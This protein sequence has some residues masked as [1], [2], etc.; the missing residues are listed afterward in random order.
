MGIEPIPMH[1]VKILM[2]KVCSHVTKFGPKIQPDNH[3]FHGNSVVMF[4]LS[5]FDSLFFVRT[6]I[7]G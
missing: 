5:N 2:V 6:S 3:E 7:L 4:T 1:N